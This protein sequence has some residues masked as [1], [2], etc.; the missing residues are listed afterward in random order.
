MFVKKDYARFS[1]SLQTSEEFL[2]AIEAVS[3][4]SFE[5]G[6]N[7]NIINND[8]Y[9]LWE[10]GGREQEIL[11]ALPTEQAEESEEIFL[12]DL[13]AVFNGVKWETKR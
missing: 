4:A 7:E 12:S 9:K 8:A 1:E 3:G 10:D 13:T 6:D 11:N 2:F 5:R